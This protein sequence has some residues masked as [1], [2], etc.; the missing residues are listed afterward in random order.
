MP[1]PTA[2][3]SLLFGNHHR[4][5]GLAGVAEFH[6]DAICRIHFKEM[7]DALAEHA[8]FQ[9]L[10]Q[11]VGSEDVGHLFEK[12]TGV[13]FAFHANAEFTQTVDPA[14]H[15]RTRNANL[16]RNTCAADDNCRVFSEEL[17]QRGDGAFG[18]SGERLLDG[19][20]GHEKREV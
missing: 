11:R 16:A 14:P 8:A 1:C 17:Q 10:P 9:S 3:C 19:A 18:R 4:P 15:R 20:L 5:F 2:A 12:I 13:L 7:I 6:R